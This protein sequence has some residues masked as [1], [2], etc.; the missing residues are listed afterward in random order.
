MAK[1]L[2][3]IVSPFWYTEIA[4]AY[5]AANYQFY[6]QLV[7]YEYDEKPFRKYLKNKDY[8][9]SAFVP[10]N[11][12]IIW[13]PSYQQQLKKFIESN[14]QH[15]LYIYGELDPWG[16]T[17]A[18]IIPDSGSLRLVQKGGT[19][20]ASISTL[21]Q[22]QKKQAIETLEKWLEMDIE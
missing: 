14:P 20:G 19:H 11:V 13:D 21:S 18:E 2:F 16:A 10:D 12:D 22:E 3:Q 8:P 7:Y 9:N 6:T 4:K 17:A 5:Q 15:M 1:F